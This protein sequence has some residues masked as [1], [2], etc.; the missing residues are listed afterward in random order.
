VIIAVKHCSDAELSSVEAQWQAQGYRCVAK[1]REK[2]LL[3]MEYLKRGFHIP[4][5][6]GVQRWMLVRRE[7]VP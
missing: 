7:P 2:D 5:Y 3:L 4:A 1:E 6:G